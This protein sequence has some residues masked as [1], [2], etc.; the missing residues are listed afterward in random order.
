VD[1]LIEA[2][3]KG[4]LVLAGVIVVLGLLMVVLWQL[5][6]IVRVTRKLQQL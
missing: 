2:L 3:G 1:P 6:V 5:G 4:A